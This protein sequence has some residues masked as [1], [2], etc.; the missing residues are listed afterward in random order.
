MQAINTKDNSSIPGYLKYRDRGFMHF[1]HPIFIPFLQEVDQVLKVVVNSK[2]L[3][4]HGD[5]LI[6]VYTE[7]QNTTI[8]VVYYFRWLTVC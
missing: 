4:E 2:A 1:P 6:K 5:D 8:Y 7:I 3:N